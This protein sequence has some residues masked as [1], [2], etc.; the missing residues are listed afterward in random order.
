MGGKAQAPPEARTALEWNGPP[1]KP[2]FT[3]LE[4]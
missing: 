1:G 3:V 4:N 2:R